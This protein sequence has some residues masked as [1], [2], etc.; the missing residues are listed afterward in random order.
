[1]SQ[2]NLTI[3]F[4]VRE[5]SLSGGSW[6]PARP[7]ERANALPL[8]DAARSADAA[9]ASTMILAD[10]DDGDRPVGV[11]ALCDHNLSLDA[12]VR[13]ELLNDSDVVLA[14]SGWIDAWPEVYGA[15][16]LDWGDPS[17]MSLRPESSELTQEI[18]TFAHLFSS[19]VICRKARINIDDTT[20]PD[21]YVEV[22]F[23]AVTGAQE[24]AINPSFGMR[25]GFEPRSRVQVS[26]GGVRV[27]ERRNKPR[28]LQGE[29]IM[30]TSERRSLIDRMQ[31]EADLDR[32]FVVIQEPS[33]ALFKPLT[34]WLA[35]FADL[36]PGERIVYGY[37]RQPF[38][39]EQ[40]L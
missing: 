5:T 17:F 33:E 34:Q 35:H 24:L 4:P 10:V 26:Q 12:R 19:N 2:Q 27:A 8:A 23:V 28:V 20:N 13:V 15:F 37:D 7:V 36:S 32:P 3:G 6:D 40:V 1:M 14:D 29:L 21:G 16:S 9:L 22:G 18:G 31:R 11:V 30:E 39:F 25:E 38:A